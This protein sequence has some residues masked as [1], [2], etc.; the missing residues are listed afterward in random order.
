MNETVNRRI[1]E[2]LSFISSPFLRFTV[3][4]VLPVAHKSCSMIEELW[5]ISCR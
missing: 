1:G 4:P 3:S 2:P 5:L